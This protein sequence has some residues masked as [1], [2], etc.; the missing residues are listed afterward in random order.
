MKLGRHNYVVD[1]TQ[2]MVEFVSVGAFPKWVKYNPFVTFLNVLFLFVF[3][4]ILPTGQTVGPIF[5]LHGS[6]DVYLRE[7]GLL[8]G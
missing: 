2:I 6:N 4:S 5:T 8:G 1:I 3:F 7:D